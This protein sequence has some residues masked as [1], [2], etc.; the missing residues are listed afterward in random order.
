MRFLI[1]AAPTGNASRMNKRHIMGISP[2]VRFHG[3]TS[4]V[5]P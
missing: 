4:E 1:I 2:V 3:R 5:L